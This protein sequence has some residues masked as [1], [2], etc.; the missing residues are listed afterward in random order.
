MELLNSVK[1]VDRTLNE[2]REA[3]DRIP[4][5]PELAEDPVVQRAKMQETIFS[6][7]LI[8][9]EGSSVENIPGDDQPLIKPPYL[10]K[11][12]RDVLEV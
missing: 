10:G 11:R 6:I 1:N 3:V 8:G 12:C 7:G 2:V 5:F 4:S 9:P